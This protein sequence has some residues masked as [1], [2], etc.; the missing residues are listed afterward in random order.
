MNDVIKQVDR[1]YKIS[2]HYTDTDSLYIHKKY[3]SP[4]VDK[5]FVGKSPGLD[6]IDCDNSGLFF[7]WFPAPKIKYCLVI[8]DFGVILA[9][10]TFKCFT[11]GHK[12]M[13]LID[14]ISLLEGKTISGG[15]SIDRTKLFEGIRLPHWKQDYV[16]CQLNWCVVNLL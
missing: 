9:N 13:K 6:K 7:A 12:M 4:L 15:F 1:F 3:W 8:D 10:R 2:I 5:G 11:E 14:Y 16:D